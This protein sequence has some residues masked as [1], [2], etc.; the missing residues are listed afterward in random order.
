MNSGPYVDHDTQEYRDGPLTPKCGVCDL[1]IAL[2]DC[3]WRNHADPA[4]AIIGWWPVAIFAMVAL[5]V[6]V[7]WERGIL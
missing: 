4:T 6:A 3:T 2:C 5:A 1:P 7:A